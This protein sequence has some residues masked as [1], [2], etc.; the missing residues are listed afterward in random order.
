MSEKNVKITTLKN[1]E[2]FKAIKVYNIHKSIYTFMYKVLSS[3]YF[4]YF[5][6]SSLFNKD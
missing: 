6:M 3:K 5:E 2:I 4:S 1:S